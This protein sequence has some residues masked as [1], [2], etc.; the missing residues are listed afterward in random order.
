MSTTPLNDLEQFLILAVV[1]MGGEA[2]GVPIRREIEERGGRAISMAAVYAA[3]ERLEAR[4]LLC[5]RLSPPTPERGGR[6]RKLYS[7]TE[8]GAV[9]VREARESLDR[10][11]EGVDIDARQSA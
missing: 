11:W 4:R 7:V 1:R 9:A 5:H 10:M 6:R 2:Y 8:A 3:L